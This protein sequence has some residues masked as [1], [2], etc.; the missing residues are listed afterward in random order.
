VDLPK[1]TEFLDAYAHARVRPAEKADR[2]IAERSKPEGFSLHQN[3]FVKRQER[4]CFNSPMIQNPTDAPIRYARAS[5]MKK[6]ADLR[7]LM[8]RF[9]RSFAQRVRGRHPD[10]PARRNSGRHS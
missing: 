1:F 3:V 7:P 2:G 9:A 6:A 4:R 10:I 8:G 5:E